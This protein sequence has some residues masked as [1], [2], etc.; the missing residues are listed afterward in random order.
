MFS[1]VSRYFDNC[2][3]DNNPLKLSISKN[4]PNTFSVGYPVKT[5]RGFDRRAFVRAV[6]T[7]DPKPSVA[8]D[9]LREDS[10]R[11]Y[12]RINAHVNII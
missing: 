4:Y 8:H 9:A 7:V 3:N 2:S 10:W 5:V 12:K 6:L 11:L 1:L